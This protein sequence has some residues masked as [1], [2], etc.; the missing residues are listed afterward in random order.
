[1]LHSG[2]ETNETRF[3]EFKWKENVKRGEWR[4]GSRGE[5]E[6]EREREL[7]ES[8]FGCGTI[9]TLLDFKKYIFLFFFFFFL[10]IAM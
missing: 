1:V 4:R 3:F 8:T 5:R 10:A 9:S 2:N 7:G 6:R